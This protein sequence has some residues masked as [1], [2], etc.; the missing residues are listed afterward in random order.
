MILECEETM[1]LYSILLDWI[2]EFPETNE[3]LD[4]MEKDGYLSNNDLSISVKLQSDEKVAEQM[5]ENTEDVIGSSPYK[6]KNENV[7]VLVTLNMI[8]QL[9]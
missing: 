9:H 5:D 6:S 3:D 1:E 4:Q 7:E 8:I 2:E